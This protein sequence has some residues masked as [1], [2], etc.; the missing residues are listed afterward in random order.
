ME[1]VYAFVVQGPYRNHGERGLP[2]QIE[3]RGAY[4]KGE[5]GA[6]VPAPYSPDLNPIEDECK[7]ETQVTRQ[8]A[9]FSF[10]RCRYFRLFSVPVS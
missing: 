4:R 7:H 8:L 5:R 10:R 1:I 9:V 3:T 2:Q 6:S